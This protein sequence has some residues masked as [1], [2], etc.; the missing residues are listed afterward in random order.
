MIVKKIK[1]FE[2]AVEFSTGMSIE[3]IRETPL[4]ELRVEIEKR[5]GPIVYRSLRSQTVPHEE[6]EIS[7]EKAIHNKD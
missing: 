5:R 3:K 7:F 4:D 1:T 2:D 6:V